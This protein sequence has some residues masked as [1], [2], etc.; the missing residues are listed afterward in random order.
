MRSGRATVF[1]ASSASAGFIRAR[2]PPSTPWICATNPCDPKKG[3]VEWALDKAR[4]GPTFLKRCKGKALDRAGRAVAASS[5][6]ST[7]NISFVL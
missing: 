4:P 6:L 5:T 1:E 7:L 2:R 3:K